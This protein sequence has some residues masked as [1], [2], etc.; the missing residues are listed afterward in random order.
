MI[1]K[2]G[3]AGNSERSYLP[4]SIQSL[5][6]IFEQHVKILLVQFF[7]RAVVVKSEDVHNERGICSEERVYIIDL[8]SS[9]ESL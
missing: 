8:H 7:P 6:V 4:P 3:S 2:E 1:G 9:G 5:G